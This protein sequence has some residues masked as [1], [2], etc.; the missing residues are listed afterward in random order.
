MEHLAG[1]HFDKS[2]LEHFRRYTLGAS[3]KGRSKCRACYRLIYKEETRLGVARTTKYK[4]YHA[5]CYQPEKRP[6]KRVPDC[7]NPATSRIESEAAAA[8]EEEYNENLDG[9]CEDFCVDDEGD[10]SYGTRS[11]YQLE[12]RPQR[13]IPGLN[14]PALFRTTTTKEVDRNLFDDDRCHTHSTYQLEKR[15]KRI[16]HDRN[17][18]GALRSKTAAEK[19]Y[20]HLCDDDERCNIHH[21]RSS[22]QPEKR[23]KRGVPDR[24]DPAISRTAKAT[25]DYENLYDDDD[26]DEDL[27]MRDPLFSTPALREEI[28]TSGPL[29]LQRQADI[30]NRIVAQRRE[31]A[32]VLRDYFPKLGVKGIESIVVGLPKNIEEL[33]HILGTHS[34]TFPY[35]GQANS[36][37]YMIRRFAEEQR[38]Y[39]STVGSWDGTETLP[40]HQTYT[41]PNE[42]IVI[43]DSSDDEDIYPNKRN[44]SGDNGVFFTDSE[45]G[46][47]Q[48][49]A[50]DTDDDEISV[51]ETLTNAQ[52]IQ[53]KFNQAAANGEVLAID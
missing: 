26:Y 35:C 30:R 16:I 40:E 36:I 2:D 43:D 52:L 21:T 39:V 15:S 20:D 7:N 49:R 48:S 13:S 37:L 38:C 33:N 42:V 32:N 41:N 25:E 45:M 19:N 22:H 17:R 5:R 51:G 50:T 34:S 53:R 24:N 14:N 9:Y 11:V 46:N 44:Q 27:F 23:R 12:K 47:P 6:K 8:E 28:T 1:L 10:K 31:L 3:H 29:L 18:P 4:Y